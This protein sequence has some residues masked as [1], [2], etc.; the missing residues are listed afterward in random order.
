MRDITV[1]ILGQPDFWNLTRYKNRTG[2]RFPGA[3]IV[4]GIVLQENPHSFIVRLR[5]GSVIKRHKRKHVVHV[6]A[7]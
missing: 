1:K 2:P 4:G 5:D 6:A 7:A 3:G